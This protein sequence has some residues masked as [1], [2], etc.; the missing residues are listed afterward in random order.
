MGLNTPRPTSLNIHGKKS[1]RPPESEQNGE[2]K[3][4]EN[5]FSETTL[6]K[7]RKH[8]EAVGEGT[9]PKPPFVKKT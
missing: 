8:L 4:A 7:W 1:D 2:H 6:C 3:G 5:P 9:A